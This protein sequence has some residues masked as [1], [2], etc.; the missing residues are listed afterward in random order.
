MSLAWTR[1]DVGAESADSWNF[2]STGMCYSAKVVADYR[3]YVR[4]FCATV[5]LKQFYNAF[6]L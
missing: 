6:W 3:A 4:P 1:L 5:D 2:T